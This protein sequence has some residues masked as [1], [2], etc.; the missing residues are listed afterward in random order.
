VLAITSP[1]VVKG[2]DG[3][4]R[5][6]VSDT[7][8][9]LQLGAMLEDIRWRNRSAAGG[10]GTPSTVQIAA[11]GKVLVVRGGNVQIAC[12]ATAQPNI[13]FE[14]R[15]SVDGAI[16]EA[17]MSVLAGDSKSIRVPPGLS[18]SIGG[19]LTLQSTAATAAATISGV[20]FNGYTVTP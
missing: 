10:A 1:L 9:R 13:T 4:Y 8:G 20:S 7:N 2:Q 16:W 6:L 3:A 12:G 15:D 18:S 5:L 17:Q 19:S 11:A 14:L